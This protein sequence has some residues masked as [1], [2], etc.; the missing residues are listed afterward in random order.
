M[1]SKSYQELADQVRKVMNLREEVIASSFRELEV[2]APT[3]A[4]LMLEE[5]GDRCRAAHWAAMPLRSFEGRCVYQVLADGEIDLLWDRLVG[6]NSSTAPCQ[7]A[8][9][10]RSPAGGHAT[11]TH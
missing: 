9:N 10:E 4:R 1:L 2:A 3:L 5:L 8:V 6:A 7:A 11:K